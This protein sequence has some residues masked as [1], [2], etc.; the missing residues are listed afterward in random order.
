MVSKMK[1]NILDYVSQCYTQTDGE[2]IADVINSC[3]K[4]NEKAIVSFSD[5]YAVPSS[6]VN[7][8]FISLL[9][10]FTFDEIRAQVMFVNTTKQI[11]EM[12]KKRFDFEVYKRPKLHYPLDASYC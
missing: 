10:E 7:A 3:L 1:I 12:I 11:N 8:A 4:N 9:D 6:F 2:V 5:I